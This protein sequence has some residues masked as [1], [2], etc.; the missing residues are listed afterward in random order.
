MKVKHF[1]Q[2]HNLDDDLDYQ[3]NDW[4][5]NNPDVEIEEIQYRS[6]ATGDET[7]RTRYSYSAFILYDNSE[8][9]NKC[10]GFTKQ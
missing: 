10:I 9:E 5:E 2:N 4:L 8:E 1:T 7:G 3:I 6:N